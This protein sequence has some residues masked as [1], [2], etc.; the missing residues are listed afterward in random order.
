MSL[1]PAALN[2]VLLLLLSSF[3]AQAVYLE[4]TIYELP[5][6]KSFISK[7]IYN[8]TQK[9]NLYSITAVK[10]DKPGPG[11][12][13]RSEITEGEL[14]FTPLNFTLAP[15][16]SEFFKLFYRGP[17]DDRERYY[18]IQFREMPVTLFA[19]RGKGRESIAAP[20]IAMDT[21]FVV[22]PRK[23]ILNYTLDETQ[24][25]LK[26][27]GNTF[28]K[29]I[30]HNGCRSTDDEATVRYVLPGQIWRSQELK[31]NNKKFIVALQKYIPVGLGCF[32]IKP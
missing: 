7:R 24:G 32:R 23:I 1:Y 12:E 3:S 10:I 6:D 17:Q 15:Q 26:N 8:D 20:A 18:R 16:G 27:T 4:S 11:G 29:I 9:Q 14:L 31:A 13:K 28:F 21:I 2:A 25:V 22:R 19:D 5:A 30:V